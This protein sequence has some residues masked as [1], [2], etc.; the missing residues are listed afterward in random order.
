MDEPSSFAASFDDPRV[1][2]P[3]CRRYVDERGSLLLVGVVHDHPASVGRVRTILERDQPD[4]LALELPPLALSLYRRYAK[5][6]ADPPRFG[7]E[8]SAAIEAAPTATVEAIDAPNMRFFTHLIERLITDRPSRSTIRRVGW[9]LL[10][11]TRAALTCRLAA[12]LPTATSSTIIPDEPRTYTCSETDPPARQAAHER[13]HV[14][15]IRA[16]IGASSPPPDRSIESGSTVQSPD[17]DPDVSD[18]SD[19]D[20]TT[21]ADADRITA[22]IGTRSKVSPPTANAAM[23]RDRIRERTMADAISRLRARGDVVAIVG[24]D[25]LD[26]IASQVF[27]GTSTHTV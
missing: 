17:R 5:T 9:S 3:F 11:A 4:V 16:L 24:F 20:R 22:S 21:A 8:M 7:G 12:S 13:A 18:V 15:G 14:A 6:N 2:A 1:S 25:H 26:R 10:G 27:N 19:T 23:Y